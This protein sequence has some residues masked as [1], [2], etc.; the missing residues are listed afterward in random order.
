M[1]GTGHPPEGDWLGTPYLRFERQ[2][3][4]ALVTVDRPEARNAMTAAM[5]FGLRYAV[6][7]VNRDDGLAGLLV[8]GAGDVFVRAATSA[9]ARPTTGGSASPRAAG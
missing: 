5:Y 2:G 9:R 3:S 8:T 4:L 6:D 7:R 1:T